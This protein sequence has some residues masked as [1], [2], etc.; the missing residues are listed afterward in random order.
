MYYYLCSALYGSRATYHFIDSFFDGDMTGIG[1]T[2]SAIFNTG[3]IIAK[4]K[5]MNI[6]PF[7]PFI[8]PLCIFG[9]VGLYSAL[10]SYSWENGGFFYYRRRS[11]KSID[12]LQRQYTMILSLMTGVGF[13]T[14]LNLPAMTNTAYT[15]SVFYVMQKMIEYQ[16]FWN[17]INGYFTIFFSS[18]VTWRMALYLHK[19][20]QIFTNMIKFE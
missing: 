8:S 18:I 9:C 12:Y 16:P 1:V 3:L 5:N 19:N 13:G 15:Y 2:V 17:G 14:T 7:Q 11:T 6:K 4:W 20:P 10:L